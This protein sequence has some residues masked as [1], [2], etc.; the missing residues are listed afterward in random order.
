MKQFLVWSSVLIVVATAG[1]FFARA[2]LPTHHGWQH[3]HSPLDYM[4]RE[5]D[6]SATQKSEI[7]SIWRGEKPA[8]AS[9]VREFAAESKEM[10]SATANGN[11]DEGKVQEIA[12]R[13][14]TTIAKLLVEKEKLKSQIYT[15][16]LTPDQ[17]AK[18]QKLQDRWDSRLNWIANRLE[19]T[20]D[21]SGK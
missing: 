5:L 21:T 2:D 13:Q 8:I 7:K 18:A 10:E 4:A 12:G 11:S 20:S 1:I 9:L 16:V 15:T 3:H 6:L 14:G 19:S 17:Q